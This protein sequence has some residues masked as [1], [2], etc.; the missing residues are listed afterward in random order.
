M[1][2]SLRLHITGEPSREIQ[3][4]GE[5]YRLGRD[6]DAEI[7]I[8]H[9]AISKRHALLERR[10][11]HWQL[12]DQGST[13]G[14]SWKGRSVQLLALR[15]GDR[16]RL[17]PEADPSLP[18]LEFLEPSSRRQRL[19]WR[20]ALSSGLLSLAGAGLLVLGFG[21]V[22]V[23]VRGSLAPVRG[24]LVLYDRSGTPINSGFDTNHREKERVADFAPS[25]RAALL[26]SE[27]TR[28][29]W[30]PGVDPIGITRALLVNI[31]GGQVLEGGS[32]LTQQLARSLYPNEVGEGDTLQR[33]WNE[34]LVALQLEARFSKQTLLLSYLNRV[35]LGVG[36]GFEDAAQ[37]YFNHS[38]SALTLPQAALLVGLLPSP[39]G[40][41]PCRD[42]K[43]ALAARNG[44][45]NKMVQEGRLSAD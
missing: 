37:A 8:Q 36:W 3:L 24:P 10:H 39:N 26:S 11:G 40:H 29:W 13:N 2:P 31:A 25:L 4:L 16:I 43:A 21:A 14:L 12:R 33:K 19:P 5:V 20:K 41:D 30:H 23:P 1:S 17:G 38:A 34:L 35:Y 7:V 44:G 22:S 15:D 28:F 27:D 9:P 18:V 42:P 45:L 32:T 6:P